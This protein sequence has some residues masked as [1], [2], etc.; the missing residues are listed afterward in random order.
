M[1]TSVSE[2]HVGMGFVA[3]LRTREIGV[4]TPSHL[5]IDTGIQIC[6]FECE[7]FKRSEKSE[8]A[9]TYSTSIFTA[10]FPVSQTVLEHSRHLT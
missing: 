4:K 6:F 7:E 8:I 2:G 5:H 9:I 1:S 10:L 3:K